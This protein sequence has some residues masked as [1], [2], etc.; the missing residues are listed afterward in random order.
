MGFFTV[1]LISYV[2][3]LS[4]TLISYDVN[5]FGIFY[6][7]IFEM[8]RN[9]SKIQ[10]F[11]K[12][13][14]RIGAYKL[15]PGFCRWQVEIDTYAGL[16]FADH[17]PKRWEKSASP[18]KKKTFLARPIAVAD[19]EKIVATSPAANIFSKIKNLAHVRGL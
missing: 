18:P 9:V 19:D 5:F 12:F 3:R 11:I 13:V 6:I 10:N 7:Y 14:R 1:S 15:L 4:Y 17:R 16:R 2:T 8:F